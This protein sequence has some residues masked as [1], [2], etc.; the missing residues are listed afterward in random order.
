[1]QH[2]RDLKEVKLDRSWLTIGSFDGVHLG[3]QQ[4]IQTL[5]TGAKQ[6]GVPSVVVTFFP[7]PQFVLR[8]ES[9]PYYLTLPEKRAQLLAEL[10]VD[11]VFTFPFDE[12][13][14]QLSAREFISNLHEDFR[15]KELL[16]GYD[17]ALGKDRE[18]DSDLLQEIGGDL[19]Y[20][21][22]VI[23]PFKVAE[24]LVSS[25]LIRS[26][27]REG[28]VRLAN[29]LLGRE[30]SISGQVI[31]GDDRGKSLGFATCNLDVHSEVVNI[32]SGVYASK[33]LVSGKLWPAVTNIGFRP[34]FGEDL[35]LP[36]IEAHLLDFSGNLYGQDVELLFVDRL[37]DEIK[38]SLVDDLIDQIKQDVR[39]T[40]R[41]LG[42]E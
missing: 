39:K 11:Y 42:Q 31:K 23:P 10:G 37:R 18:G 7:H 22:R 15:F 2:I 5:V 8:G 40:R 34:T 14:S 38:F 29:T 17:F 16:I 24:K 1:M 28:D 21:V 19:G 27:I 36:R 25:S 32:K 13:I 41:I 20:S 26:M 35:S 6:A 33:G 9:R 12:R 4:I 30:F 3:H